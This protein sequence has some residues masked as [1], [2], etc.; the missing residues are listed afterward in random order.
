MSIKVNLLLVILIAYAQALVAGTQVPNE[1][2]KVR[3]VGIQTQIYSALNDAKLPSSWDDF[4]EYDP[5]FKSLVELE[6]EGNNITELYSFISEKDRAKFPEGELLL[7]RHKPTDWPEVW[8]H[9]HP[10]VDPSEL[11]EEQR[12]KLKDLADRQQ[13][14]RY[15]VYRNKRGD[16]DSVWWF[17]KDVQKMLAETGIK[18][19]EPVPYQASIEQASPAPAVEE[20]AEVIEEFTPSERAIEEPAEVVATESSEEPAE[21]SSRWWLWL[22]GAMVVVG[23]IGLAVRRKS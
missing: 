21:Q 18:V 19:P 3:G 13:P 22:I 6:V 11:T 2:A 12:A 20:V 7:I 15:L 10:H 23:G 16:L 4:I 1:L 9:T 8:N 17:E 14:I 5:E